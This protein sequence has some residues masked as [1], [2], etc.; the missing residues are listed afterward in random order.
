MTRIILFV[1]IAIGLVC[2][3]APADAASRQRQYDRSQDWNVPAGVRRPSG[4]PWA[5]PNE[6]YIDEGYGRFSPCR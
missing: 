4:P 3:G 6:C 5:M 1:A 2:A